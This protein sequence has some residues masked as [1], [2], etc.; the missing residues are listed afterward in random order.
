MLFVIFLEID[1]L[2]LISFI[3]EDNSMNILPNISFFVLHEKENKGQ[4]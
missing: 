2:S 4:I 3:V 1:K